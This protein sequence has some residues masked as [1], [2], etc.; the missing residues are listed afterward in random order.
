MCCD[1]L[2]IPINIG[3]EIIN[4]FQ[5]INIF[6]QTMTS[7]QNILLLFLTLFAS[8]IIPTIPQSYT[9]YTF[10]NNLNYANMEWFTCF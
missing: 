4:N 5:N 1:Q 9:S 8:F 7:V 6:F 3:N 10:S 2:H